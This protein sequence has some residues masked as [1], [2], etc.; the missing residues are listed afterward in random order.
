MVQHQINFFDANVGISAGW[1][2][3]NYGII[4]KTVNGGI[5]WKIVHMGPQLGEKFDIT[6]NDIE[7]VNSKVGYVAGSKGTVMKTIDAGDTW[8]SVYV[9]L[10]AAEVEGSYFGTVAFL[11]ELTGFVA[12][13]GIYKT[14]DGGKTWNK[15][16][17]SFGYQD[18]F[19]YDLH[20]F[21]ANNG[22]AALNIPQ[23]SNFE[24]LPLYKTTDGGLTWAP[25]QQP[26]VRYESSG[27]N[28]VRDLYFT[29]RLNGYAIGDNI[30]WK[31]IDGGE[32]WESLNFIPPT[33][34]LKM[35]VWE[36][37]K[38]MMVGDRGKIYGSTNFNEVTKPISR[39]TLPAIQN[40]CPN[41]A[42][43]FQNKGPQ[44]YTYKWY[45]N[46][47]LVS[48]DYNLTTTFEPNKDNEVKLVAEN[49]GITDFSVKYVRTEPERVFQK[50]SF[51]YPAPEPLYCQQTSIS[52][53]ING[54][55]NL[56]Y[57]DGDRGRYELWAEGKLIEIIESTASS[58]AFK[59]SL[60]DKTTTYTVKA[61]IQTRCK[62]YTQEELI[63]Y[64]FAPIPDQTL[65]VQ[66][67]EDIVCPS[68]TDRFEFKI[69]NSQIGFKYA[70]KRT[71]SPD[72]TVFDDAYDGNGGDL[73][74]K[75][76]YT[77]GTK[78]GAAT[79]GGRQEITVY[80]W[81]NQCNSYYAKPLHDKAII[82]TSDFNLKIDVQKNQLL[83]NEQLKVNN[84]SVA[85][86][87]KW[88]ITDGTKVTEYD[89][90][91]LPDISFSTPGV[92]IVKL[93]ISKHEKC[94]DS[95]KFEVVVGNIA[96]TT[97]LATCS[98]DDVSLGEGHINES[99]NYGSI[100]GVIASHEDKDGF[101]Y[102]TGSHKTRFF[103]SKFDS[104][105]KLIWNKF[106]YDGDYYGSSMGSTLISDD[107]GNIYVGG[108]YSTKSFKLDSVFAPYDYPIKWASFLLKI[109]REGKTEW[110]I[111]VAVPGN[112]YSKGIQNHITDLAIDKSQNVY[113]V[114]NSTLNVHLNF[115]DGTVQEG[116]YFDDQGK[117]QLKNEEYPVFL[118]KTN[119]EGKN[120]GTTVL[121]DNQLYAG[122]NYS[123]INF[124]NT[125]WTYR[126]DPQVEIGD[127]NKMYIV[128][129]RRVTTD[130][131]LK[132]GNY[133]IPGKSEFLQKY[134][135]GGR[136]GYVA[137][138]N[139]NSGN[140]EKAFNT[141]FH[142]NTAYD[143]GMH[144]R[145]EFDRV[146]FTLIPNGIVIGYSWNPFY[147]SDKFN[148]SE[149]IDDR[150]KKHIAANEI[151]VEDSI[152]NNIYRGSLM[153]AYDW[154]GNNLWTTTSHN[155]YINDYY[156]DTNSAKI[157]AFATLDSLS[158][159]GSSN[160]SVFHKVENQKTKSVTLLSYSPNG[161]LLKVSQPQD[162][163]TNAVAY[164]MAVG[165][166]SNLYLIS[167]ELG[168]NH[169]RYYNTLRTT[170]TKIRSV[171]LDGKCKN[172]KAITVPFTQKYICKGESIQLRIDGPD[173]LNVTWSPAASLNDPRS[174]TPTA[175]PTVSTTYF[176]K[177]ETAD[178]CSIT[179]A[180]RIDIDEP[181]E[182]PDK[183]I[184]V[185][186][187]VYLKSFTFLFPEVKGGKRY[188]FEWTFHDGIKRYKT[189]YHDFPSEG[190]YTVSLRIWNECTEK[191]I[192]QQ[193][194]VP[195]TAAPVP[196]AGISVLRN[197]SE[198]AFK[199]TNPKDVETVFWEFG[200]GSTSTE[201]EPVHTYIFDRSY[202]VRLTIRSACYENVYYKTISATCPTVNAVL[203]KQVNRQQVNFWVTGI[204][205]DQIIKWSFSDGAESTEKQPVHTFKEPGKYSATLLIQYECGT[206]TR[207]IDV[208]V[209]CSNLST[210]FNTTIDRANVKFIPPVNASAV[211]YEWDF[212]D[213][214]K[215]IEASPEHIYKQSGNYLVL[216]KLTD[217][218][219]P[220]T[221]S[222][223]I[224]VCAATAF[225][226]FTF[227]IDKSDSHV[228]SFRPS[229]LQA[230]ATYLWDFGDGT[231]STQA[232]P[233]HRYAA[234]GSYNV[235]LTTTFSCSTNTKCQEVNMPTA[236]VDDVNNKLLLIYPN[237]A[238]EMLYFDI[239][240]EIINT[241]EGMTVHDALG[242]EV[243]TKTGKSLAI[244]KMI[245][246]SELS[247]GSYYIRLKI[248]RGDYIIKKFVV[249]H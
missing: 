130:N 57:Y 79:L 179:R 87:F 195:C 235:C 92:K 13:T 8:N 7:F 156:Y 212:G 222:K 208:E 215:S 112:H 167:G 107:E 72:E 38:G 150:F 213:G 221:F 164:T 105:G 152:Y 25:V 89:T 100:S 211:T 182:I 36:G 31:T 140:V 35:N 184:V 73:I 233:Q 127:D 99:I 165:K 231:T 102:V 247:T 98:E 187:R 69:K 183:F 192:T 66:E 80:A 117:P 77:G 172:V 21:D 240:P 23:F 109:N 137:V 93:F 103:L 114:F 12:G 26:G 178:G 166:C 16:A 95:V 10:P 90:P 30:A 238:N 133:T 243:L 135:D 191:T 125:W 145:W 33:S 143:L 32:N 173:I 206:T 110:I 159:I 123:E 64:N 41:T 246:I 5:D 111:K 14:Q 242:R 204:T 241:V 185:S 232:T 162:Q 161:E 138:M 147:K 217:A 209:T 171:A 29:D 174:L 126:T 216:L 52:V 223:T 70:V 24:D 207:T 50:F 226:D 83:V 141:Y 148:N 175:T 85:D 84:L 58:I 201:L 65:E 55:P 78:Y 189:V 193:I 131:E 62:S 163:A 22:V 180:I 154:S 244:T 202:N 82:Q 122:W 176:A 224:T 18:V 27:G 46:N 168:Q 128:G 146:P 139:L 194:K 86:V 239:A 210:D 198:V 75:T 132:I 181:L 71:N 203:Q 157:L 61:N 245:D 205:P 188:E 42:Y 169:L 101:L 228:V 153:A 51:A 59:P 113:A 40:Y 2:L 234:T 106:H 4:L 94:V 56:N 45:V 48:T 230:G 39:F 88:T 91:Q 218:C 6:Y 54:V 44:H 160:A 37:K 15:L 120:L 149:R 134:P 248:K 144:N 129:S 81:Y 34:L 17:T 20:F 190:T 63:T 196:T 237:P 108:S 227:T 60:L 236:I 119:K 199:L 68:S 229:T 214:V 19:F 197:G 3:F 53:R 186:D 124:S 11:D 142:E 225:A 67:M 177:I 104:S 9:P 219:G 115:P 28:V 43:T 136:Q 74:I 1:S 220:V 47:T 170:E 49:K 249:Q 96:P 97:T 116:I 158:M 118:L 151:I 200:D 155:T 76:L 121:I